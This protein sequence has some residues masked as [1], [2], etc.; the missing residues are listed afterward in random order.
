MNR[1]SAEFYRAEPAQREWLARLLRHGLE[2][3]Q[4]E[5]T[6][7][8]ELPAVLLTF[9][10]DVSLL[11]AGETHDLLQTAFAGHRAMQ[12]AAAAN[13]ALHRAMW[14]EINKLGIYI[15]PDD[16]L[17]QAVA[18]LV[19]L[20]AKQDEMIETQG[21][22]TTNDTENNGTEPVAALLPDAAERE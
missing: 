12:A 3:A 5:E 21:R 22:D 10:C 18:M 19:E 16:S 1:L 15:D 2:M 17:R 7:A 4:H 14:D 20:V 9:L 8:D 13:E 6:P 11:T